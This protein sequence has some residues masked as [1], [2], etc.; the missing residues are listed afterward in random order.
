MTIL[1]MKDYCKSHRI[2]Y[3]KLA[4]ASGVSE[5][6]IKNIFSGFTKNPRIDT[7]EKLE[8]GLRILSN[9]RPIDP[10]INLT[11]DE[12]KIIEYYRLLTPQNKELICHVLQSVTKSK[13]PF[14]M[15]QVK[16]VIYAN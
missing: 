15:Q 14:P 7:V 6:V 16:E 9:F 1:E 13:T 5:G 3:A 12:R 10:L 4:E 2:T 11:F 8:Y